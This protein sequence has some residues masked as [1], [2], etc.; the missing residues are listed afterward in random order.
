MCSR[1]KIED[2]WYENFGELSKLILKKWIPLHDPF[3]TTPLDDCCL[4]PVDK[5]KMADLIGQPVASDGMDFFFGKHI[6]E[7]REDYK[8]GSTYVPTIDKDRFKDRWYWCGTCDCAA[9]SC[10]HCDNSSCNG[11][12][13]D[14]CHQDFIY[15][16]FMKEE[17][18]P[19]KEDIPHTKE[20]LQAMTR[21]ELLAK[22][23]S[24]EEIQEKFRRSEELYKLLN[25]E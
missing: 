9:I 22:G 6:E 15:I 1:F 13:C 2:V 7:I 3:E 17:D 21:K 24:E 19:K 20:Q 25:G 16:M 12:G 10:P 14:K 4:C 18:R 8:C 5:N 23:W 11:G